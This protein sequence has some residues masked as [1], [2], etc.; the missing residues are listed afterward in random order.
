MPQIAFSGAATSPRGQNPASQGG[1]KAVNVPQGSSGP[2]SA[3]LIIP[4]GRAAKLRTDAGRQL[5]GTL[6]A[7]TQQLSLTPLPTTGY[8][9]TFYL[10]ITATAAGNAANVA[11]NADGPWNFIRNL[12]FRDATGIPIHNLLTG[13][14]EYIQS[15]WGGYRLGR[16]EGSALAFT[17][18]LGAVGAGGSFQFVLPI[19]QEF[20]RDTL[21]PLANMDAS[22]GYQLDLT[23]G[24]IADIY[25]VAPT[26]APTFTIN[27]Y[28]ESYTNP[29]DEIDG[30]PC[31]TEPP[32]LGTTQFWSVQN[33]SWSGTG[34]QTVQIVRV[35]NLIRNI[36]LVW[37]TAGGARSAGVQP[38]A[39]SNLRF[40]LDQTYLMNQ[41]TVLNQ[42]TI[43]RYATYDL[44]TG[45]QLIN[46]I[47]DPDNLFTGEMG[48]RYLQTMAQTR[49]ALVFTPQAAG[50]LEIM[51]ND[52]APVGDIHRWE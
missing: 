41:P 1:G 51:I 10:V 35:G 23:I 52:V 25:S 7:N 20:G 2:E 18:T 50:A 45:L 48:E 17:S 38:A 5:T 34:E 47:T 27:L 6:S 13:Y 28:L 33:Y 39:L 22:A 8:L 21:G 12:L 4:F 29:P 31:R 36:M 24:T 37:R 14:Q 30:N 49:L 3:G 40:E 9:A 44:D 11:F 43:Y 46:F 15:K 32:A 26:N 16:P 42:F 19:Y